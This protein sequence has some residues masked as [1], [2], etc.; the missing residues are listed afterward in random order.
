MTRN[1]KRDPNGVKSFDG[2]SIAHARQLFE[3]CKEKGISFERL[4]EMLA[5][6]SVMGHALQ[7]GLDQRPFAD[8]REVAER[9]A[10]DLSVNALFRD[11]FPNDVMTQALNALGMETMSHDAL[12]AHVDGSMHNFEQ[13]R[14]DDA[15]EDLPFT[16]LALGTPEE[17][18]RVHY[19]ACLREYG[20]EYNDTN[21]AR[22][23]SHYTKER[24]FS[25]GVKPMHVRVVFLRLLEVDQRTWQFPPIP[26]GYELV[27]Y[28]FFEAM[29]RFPS[30]LYWLRLDLKGGYRT[31][32]RIRHRDLASP[33][34]AKGGEELQTTIRFEGPFRAPIIE[35]LH[36]VPIATIGLNDV[37][38][39]M[40]TVAQISL[41]EVLASW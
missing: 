9:E 29:R 30:L 13:I 25:S 20:E 36:P 21:H 16:V 39:C 31:S 22:A 19:E 3:R 38:P 5:H 35:S 7:A 1:R 8:F 26:K 23:V 41:R 14:V 33:W 2:F 27:S 11:A 32:V 34:V 15:G 28:E 40:R 4:C 37:L 10:S 12:V 18:L 17:T 6:P 24:C